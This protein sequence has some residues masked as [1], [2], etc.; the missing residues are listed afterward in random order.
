MPKVLVANRGE[1]AIRILRSAAELGWKTVAVYTENDSSHASFAEEAVKLDSVADFLDVDAIVKVAAKTECTH[2]HPGY[3][4]LS[5]SP[6]LPLALAATSSIVFVG[7]SPDALK[8]SSD[9]MLSRDLASS[10]G[11]NIA[12][13]IRVSSAADVKNFANDIGFPIMIKALDG[14]GGRGIRIVESEGGVEEAFKRCLGESPS[15]QIFAEKALTGPG[16]KHIEVQIIGDGTNVNHLWERE[17]SVQR[18]FQKIV[19]SAPSRLPRA[20]IQPLLDSSLKIA[21][22]LKYRG[23]GTFEYLVNTQTQDWVFLEI[24]PRVQVEHTI[25]E[26]ICDTDL[27]RAQLLLFTPNATLASVQLSAQPP[28]PSSYSIQLRLTAEDPARGFQLSPGPLDSGDLSWPA[29]RGVRVDTWLTNGPYAH[30]GVV[31]GEWEVGTDFDSLLAKVIVRGRTFEE[32]T[33]KARRALRELNIGGGVKTN[34]SVLAGVIEHPDWAA[35]TIDTLW[36]ERNAPGILE[37]GNTASA[38]SGDR[39]GQSR[40]KPTESAT[41]SSFAGNGI[42]LQPGTLFNLSLSGLSSSSSATPSTPSSKHSLTLLSISQNAFPSSLSGT[43]QTSFS[44]M[45]LE[46][47]LNQS[48][49]AAVSSGTFEFA[50]L[51]NAEH[52]PSPMT[53]KVV[54]LHPALAVDAGPQQ[55]QVRKGE[56]LLIVSVMKM[57]NVIS[58]PFDGPVERIGKG[59]KVGVVL[60]EGMLICVLGKVVP[61]RL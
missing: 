16:W 54:E 12:A 46:F 39:R 49:S 44:P 59:V 40:A 4:F 53:G 1:I 3:G 28:L 36:L 34:L 8:I 27:V 31:D 43:L 52:I 58:A 15:K 25:T 47:S 55:R 18:R 57:E 7:P 42:L 38:S 33:A 14:G 24:N 21:S 19:E 48:T 56:P 13:G 2:I 9:K 50:D 60:G 37:L 35:G 22:H 5:E 61:S 41:S 32:A 17:C 30:N 51:N 23:L 6:A 20:A 10:L 11:V 45:P 26:E 29:G